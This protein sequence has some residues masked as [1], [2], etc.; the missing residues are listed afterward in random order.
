MYQIRQMSCQVDTN[1][2]IIEWTHQQQAQYHSGLRSIGVYWYFELWYQGQNVRPSGIRKCTMSSLTGTQMSL[3]CP[4]RKL[5]HSGVAC[6]CQ[7][8]D[9]FS[10]DIMAQ[11]WSIL[12]SVG[13]VNATMRW[14]VFVTHLP[15]IV[16]VYCALTLS[17]VATLKRLLLTSHPGNTYPITDQNWPYSSNI[18]THSTNFFQ[19]RIEI[20][21]QWIYVE[22]WMMWVW[23]LQTG[24]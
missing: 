1:L 2:I 7:E 17:Q 10:W 5:F 4:S 13:R 22:V 15:I 14:M 3:C 20:E 8:I 21:Q 18:G 6:R 19:S 16:F 24:W 11:W 12:H 9:W 23:A